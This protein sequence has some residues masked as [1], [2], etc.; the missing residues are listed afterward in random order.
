MSHEHKH[1]Q[2]HNPW[3]STDSS[4]HGSSE[5]SHHSSHHGSTAESPSKLPAE[6]GVHDNE[7]D[8]IQGFAQNK[9]NKAEVFHFLELAGEK[10]NPETY[11]HK[12]SDKSSFGD[13]LQYARNN[14]RTKG[15]VKAINANDAWEAC[16]ILADILAK[17]RVSFNTQ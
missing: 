7:W 9:S 3:Q 12:F 10:M 11:D 13:L 1:R 15:L 6:I 14:R 5:S 17:F 8:L 16:R 4:G 2:H